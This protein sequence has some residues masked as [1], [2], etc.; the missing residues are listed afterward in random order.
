MGIIVSS[1][2]GCGKTYLKNTYGDKIVIKESIPSGDVDETY[3]QNTL[4]LASESDIVFVP[5]T[6]EIRNILNEHNVDYDLFYPSKNRRLEF[7]EN[8][9]RKRVKMQ[10]IQEMDNNFDKWIDE[11]ESDESENCYKHKLENR[12]EFIANDSTIMNYIT[13]VQ[14]S[15]NKK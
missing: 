1:F 4:D 5:S 14:E 11:I 3:I 6:K 13:S 2:R 15:Q 12:N 7:V 10:S 8:Q 9:A